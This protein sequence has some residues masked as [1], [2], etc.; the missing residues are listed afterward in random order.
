MR[1]A[2]VLAVLAV[3]ALCLPPFAALPVQ[4][5]TMSF[6]PLW[7]TF[8][9]DVPESW[10]VEPYAI[11]VVLRPSPEEKRT[12]LTCAVTRNNGRTA[13]DLAEQAIASL[14]RRDPLAEWTIAREEAGQVWVNVVERRV[15][16][17]WLF[18]AG[19]AFLMLTIEGDIGRLS[20]VAAT[21][22]VPPALLVPPAPF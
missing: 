12:M 22:R 21:L 14:R 4:A 13:R 11:G 8:T 1:R 16:K 2:T 17:Q 7:C 6:G 15:R 3:L 9:L 5:R 18:M 19:E 10:D 20:P